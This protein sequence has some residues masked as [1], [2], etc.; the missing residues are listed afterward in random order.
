MPDLR[1][2]DM[3]ETKRL[4]RSNVAIVIPALNEA[5]RIR[6]VVEGALRHC[7]LVVVIDDGSDDDTVGCIADL[8][9]TVLRHA[10]RMG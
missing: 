3:P 1:N 2:R 7:D 8:P 6:G 9:V 4:D 10:Q 5:L